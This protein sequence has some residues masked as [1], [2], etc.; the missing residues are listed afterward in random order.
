MRR[1]QE[2]TTMAREWDG[3]DESMKQR[4]AERE[5]EIAA[6]REYA[7]SPEGRLE[8]LRKQRDAR[9]ADRSDSGA[10]H[11]AE[12]AELTAQIEA[13]QAEITAQAEAEHLAAWPRE[14][15]IQRRGE[16]NARA[17]KIQAMP[18]PKRGAALLALQRELGYTA[19]DLRWAVKLHQL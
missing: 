9:Y 17:V 14:L 5:A 3:T 13:L 7:Q 12:I 18:R 1:E 10:D 19:N 6:N 15:T 11:R 2:A 4:I 8:A 16:W